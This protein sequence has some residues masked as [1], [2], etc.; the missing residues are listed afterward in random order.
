MKRPGTLNYP[1]NVGPWELEPHYSRHVGAM[2]SEGLHDKQDIAFQLALRDKEI[3]LLR[4]ELLA[5]TA[6]P[7]LPESVR[8]ELG[9][10][11]T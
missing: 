2:T 6:K 3:E 9:E 1:K 10:C 8:R 4:R 7:D 11:P 5:A